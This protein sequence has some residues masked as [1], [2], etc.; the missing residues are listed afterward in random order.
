[1]DFIGVLPKVQS[2]DT[3]MVVVDRKTK[4]AHFVPVKHPYTA[5][6]IAELFIKEIVRLH[7]FPSSIVS[8][9]DRVFLCSFWTELFQQAGIKLKYSSAYHPQSD[10][11]KHTSD[12]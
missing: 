6:D 1:M 2:I 12:A 4:Y 10:A 3:I 8:D 9:R 11:W 5:K 7:G